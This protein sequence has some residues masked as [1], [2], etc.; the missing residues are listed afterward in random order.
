MSAEQIQQWTAALGEQWDV[1]HFL[2]KIRQGVFV[3]LEAG[4]FED[5]LSRI[6]LADE[7]RLLDREF[8]SVLWYVPLFLHWNIERVA[9]KSGNQEQFE[10]FA[11]RVEDEISRIFGFAELTTT[12]SNDA[13]RDLR[14]EWQNGGFLEKVSRGIF[15]EEG[16]QRFKQF[17]ETVEVSP[18]LKFL[19]REMVSSVWKA[20]LY[21]ERLA[22]SYSSIHSATS[23]EISRY[24]TLVEN[25]LQQILGIP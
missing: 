21:L 19:D 9:K 18:Q 6:E 22:D 3:E 20:P 5:L 10:T 4:K 13:F 7:D 8:V 23:Q 12:N 17:L 24:A 2:W 15:D 25:E 1:G 11:A 14:R 16:S